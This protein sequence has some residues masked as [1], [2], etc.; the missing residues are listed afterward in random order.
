MKQ[1][2]QALTH[3][4]NYPKTLVEEADYLVTDDRGSRNSWRHDQAYTQH[5]PKSIEDIDEEDEDAI[6]GDD[7]ELF[8]ENVNDIGDAE[9]SSQWEEFCFE[10]GSKRCER[11]WQPQRRKHHSLTCSGQEF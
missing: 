9:L 7:G 4:R 2:I 6:L 3:V 1:Y 5:P 8:E 11:L 10:P